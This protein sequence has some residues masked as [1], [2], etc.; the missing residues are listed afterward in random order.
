MVG[1]KGQVEEE[2]GG[3]RFGRGCIDQIFELKQLV[4]SIERRCMLNSCTW[5]RNIKMFVEKN[6][7]VDGFLCRV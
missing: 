6:C 3:F 1:R 7:G 5:K 2:Q 4:E